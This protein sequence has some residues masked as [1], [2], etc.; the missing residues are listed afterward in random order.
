[1]GHLSDSFHAKSEPNTKNPLFHAKAYG[2]NDLQFFITY[3][4][5]SGGMF[6]EFLNETT[7][8]EF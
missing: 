3:D 6:I 4:T 8:L 7:V 2:L 5:I 1:M